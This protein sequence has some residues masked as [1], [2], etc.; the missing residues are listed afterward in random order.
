ML[1][2]GAVA[3]VAGAVA[4]V[5]I[6]VGTG[7]VD[8]SAVLP[9]TEV[10]GAPVAAGPGGESS[11]AVAKPPAPAPSASA[12]VSAS[13]SDQSV[14]GCDGGRRQRG[15]ERALAGLGGYPAITVD[16]KASPADCSAIRSFQKRYGIRPAHGQADATTA[17]VAR[18]LAASPLD[19]C[20][21]AAG[22][23]ACVDLT[24]QT[25]WVVRDGAVVFGPTVVRTGFRGHTTPVGRF[26]VNLRAKREWSNPYKVWLPYWQ[27]FE[28]GNGFHETTS[29]LHD[30]WRGSHGCV[31]LL[32]RDAVAMWDLL[33]KGTTV[34]TFGRR[35]GT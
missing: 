22:V 21:A 8:V 19:E 4:V 33:E 3:W 5:G 10:A 23:T 27:R 28:G 13:A 18:R 7:V 6:A 12:S 14:K 26:S 15:I 24:T 32:H 31:N 16:G 2:S 25:A 35:P 34:R 17:D 1:M 30:K 11:V 20:G 29:Y 9:S